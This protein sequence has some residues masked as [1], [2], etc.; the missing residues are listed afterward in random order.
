[1]N[2]ARDFGCSDDDSMADFN[3]CEERGAAS[4]FFPL[5]FAGFKLIGALV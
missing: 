3:I 2:T 5:V 4:I 1:M